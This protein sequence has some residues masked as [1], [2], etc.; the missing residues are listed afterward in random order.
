MPEKEIKVR[1]LPSDIKPDAAYNIEQSNPNSYTHSFFKY[2]CKF[3][4]EIPRWAI[5]RY[6]H[7]PGG[8]IY[9]PFSG[10]GTTLLEAAILGHHSYGSEIDATAKMITRAKTT[11]LSTEQTDSL[12]GLKN[13]I[14]AY[15]ENPASN[16]VIADISNIEHWFPETNINELGRLR[17]YIENITDP[18]IKDFCLACFASI[19]KKASF[20]DDQSPKP[21]VS[22]KILKKPESAIKAFSSTFDRYSCMITEFSGLESIRPVILPGGALGLEET[23]RFDLAVTSPPYI[24]AF[25]YARSMRLENLWLG[26]ESEDSIR[27]SKDIYV[28][29]EKINGSDAFAQEAYMRDSPLLHTYLDRIITV[30]KK[31]A[32]VVNKFFADMKTNMRLV[33]DA[34]K[35]GCRY[36]I[37]IG[38]SSIRKVDIESWK[39]LSEIGNTIGLD[40]EMHFSYKIKNPYIRIPREGQG[41]KISEDHVLILRKRV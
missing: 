39:V 36:V 13:D 25:D 3:I 9:D 34:L 35:P 38:N 21:Y 20:C 12:P 32:A 31:R 22:T 30:D 16:A 24:N 8:H 33:H 7:E 10:S 2:P 6:V 28:G 1:H 40:T 11:R 5:N 19:I 27:E 14:V 26:Y 4:P 23:D 41:G 15:V 29:T 17:Y 37:V 18:Q